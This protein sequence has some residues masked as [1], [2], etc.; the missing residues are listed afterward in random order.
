MFARIAVVAAALA[1]APSA[2]AADVTLAD[3]SRETGVSERHLR[4]VA[5]ART[6]YPEYRIV[7]DR[8]ER[9]LKNTLGDEG[10]HY[11]LK[12]EVAAASEAYRER[13]AATAARE[14]GAEAAKARNQG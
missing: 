12:G 10:Y 6:P 11:L 5:G 4:M 8:V 9:Q 1:V 13:A 7:F 14:K 3:L 2:F